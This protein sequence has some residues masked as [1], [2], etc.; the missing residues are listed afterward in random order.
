MTV[1]GL[2]KKCRSIECWYIERS[3]GIDGRQAARPEQER[4]R[5]AA[6]PKQELEEVA[7][8]SLPCGY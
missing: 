2:L 1:T 6:R 3:V 8:G 4:R 7:V 5:Q